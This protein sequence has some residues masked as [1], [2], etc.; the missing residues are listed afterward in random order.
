M[1]TQCLNIWHTDSICPTCEQTTAALSKEI[2]Q[3]TQMLADERKRY[4]LARRTVEL[5]GSPDEQNAAHT[6][7]VKELGE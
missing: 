3:L 1:A 2:A 7:A 4:E 5:L 6:Q